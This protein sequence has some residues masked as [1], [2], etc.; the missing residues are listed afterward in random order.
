M[1]TPEDKT[2]KAIRSRSAPARRGAPS[3]SPRASGTV[4]GA[5]RLRIAALGPAAR[6]SACRRLAGLLLL[7]PLGECFTGLV[8]LC[9][10]LTHELRVLRWPATSARPGV[11]AD[12]Y[13]VS[14]PACAC[15]R[16]C[17]RACAS[18]EYHGA[19]GALVRP[20]CI[21]PSLP[22]WQVLTNKRTAGECG[23]RHPHYEL[24]RLCDQL[25]C[26]YRRECGDARYTHTAIAVTRNFVGSPHIDQFDQCEQLAISLGEFEG[27]E[28]C[29]EEDAHTVAVHETRGRIAKVDGR[30]VHWVRAFRG[31]D[32]FSL[33]FY[34]TVGLAEDVS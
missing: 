17:A 19:H 7:L 3:P 2:Q 15:A 10:L 31:G 12:E 6:A 23:T 1:G 34:N 33:I 9:R 14:A 32:R 24:R 25:L 29:V 21:Q 28:L 26:W 27:G 4:I 5:A 8:Q 16:A 13:L 18:E 30:R 11:T 20:S 22:A